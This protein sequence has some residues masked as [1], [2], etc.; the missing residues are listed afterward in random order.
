[1]CVQAC[2]CTLTFGSKS[3]EGQI[4]NK[5]DDITVHCKCYHY[6]LATAEAASQEVR[7]RLWLYALAL[8]RLCNNEH[9]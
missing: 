2:A 1:M 7:A 5:L 9:V 8:Y 6:T 4:C 3:L